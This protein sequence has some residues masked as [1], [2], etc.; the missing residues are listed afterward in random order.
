MPSLPKPPTIHISEFDDIF[1]DIAL[2]WVKK[3]KDWALEKDQARKQ[4]K[5]KA[6]LMHFQALAKESSST[7]DIINSVFKL[8]SASK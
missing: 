1:E 7:E 8:L 2:P 4:D 5:K 6:F 3:L